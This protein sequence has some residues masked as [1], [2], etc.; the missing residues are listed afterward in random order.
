MIMFRVR[1]S[2]LADSVA[3]FAP[4]A[5]AWLPLSPRSKLAAISML[6]FTMCLA[7]NQA[8]AQWHVIDEAAIASNEKSQAQQLAQLVSQYTQMVTQY[9]SMLTSLQSLNLNIISTNNQLP[10]I[11]DPSQQVSQA[12]PGASLPGM[13]LGAIGMDPAIVDGNIV[14]QQRAICTKIVLLQVDKYNTVA[15]MLNHMNDYFSGLKKLAETTDQLV[16]AVE[17]AIGNREALQ[18]QTTQAQASLATEMANVEQRLRAVDATIETLNEQQSLL[19]H[20]ALK[21]SNSTGPNAVAGQIIQA[22]AFSAA[23]AQH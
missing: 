8:H 16:G 5:M 23:F 22:A 6:L 4:F 1:R 14:T 10:L 12:C 9:E 20:V 18:N 17:H 19:A 7:T 13:A 11:T 15:T 2:V 3:L 21:G